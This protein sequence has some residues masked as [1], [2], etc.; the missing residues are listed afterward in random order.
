[1]EG[2]FVQKA[3]LDQ[4][5]EMGAQ[6]RDPSWVGGNLRRERRRSL[7]AGDTMVPGQAHN[8]TGILAY[9]GHSVDS[10]ASCEGSVES[11]GPLRAH[12]AKGRWTFHRLVGWGKGEPGPLERRWRISLEPWTAS[13]SVLGM[14]WDVE[15]SCG[16]GMVFPLGCGSSLGLG[17]SDGPVGSEYSTCVQLGSRGSCHSPRR[18]FDPIPFHGGGEDHPPPSPLP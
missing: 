10:N 13:G 11:A 17:V 4:T 12:A 2:A 1:M 18:V 9:R 15:S 5:D 8:G 14:G 6:T 7:K 16:P 3:P